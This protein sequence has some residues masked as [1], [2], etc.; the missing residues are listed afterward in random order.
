MADR[1][2]N[3]PN[4]PHYPADDEQPAWEN[5]DRTNQ[6]EPTPSEQ[7]SEIQYD[8]SDPTMSDASVDPQALPDEGLQIDEGAAVFRDDEVEDIVGSAEPDT[9]EMASSDFP[10]A[11]NDRRTF[12]GFEPAADSG[13]AKG[14]VPEADPYAEP[15]PAGEPRFAD[16]GAP[17][18]TAQ[19]T[20][21]AEPREAASV[22]EPQVAEEPIEQP[23]DYTAIPHH[24]SL[25]DQEIP[26]DVLERRQSPDDDYER[27]RELPADLQPETTET[28]EPADAPATG[29]EIDYS[30]WQE[31]ADPDSYPEVSQT[32]EEV[33]TEDAQGAPLDGAAAGVAGAAGAATAGAG[34]FGAVS[35][36][37]DDDLETTK[38]R[39]QSLLNPPEE[40]QADAEATSSW[41]PR[42][43][44]QQTD[45]VESSLFD[46]ATVVPE[47]PSR[48]GARVWSFFLTLIGLPA[49]WY[50]ITD[51]AARL[52]L[53]E[54]NP[55][56]TG[57]LNPAALA[58][59]GAGAVVAIIV[60][61]LTIRSSL[62]A[63][64][65]GFLTMVAG[66]FFLAV[67]TL[68]A[69]FMEP[70]YNWLTAFN[71]FG[72]NVAH[73]IQ[74]TGYT[75]AMLVSGLMLFVIGLTSIFARR[76]GRREQDIRTQIERLAP[77]TLKKGRRKKA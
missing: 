10:S 2:L 22:E 13:P 62:G 11:E 9:D 45:D 17:A 31:D 37:D 8:D 68:T 32:R 29:E 70:A 64:I 53:A 34:T 43:T 44:A 73:H 16:D 23:R 47:V 40:P 42:E 19:D 30:Q 52:T 25:N 59:L 35:A 4:D 49:A 24:V 61:M 39:R 38:V 7:D 48:V 41:H 1:N 12:S 60:I 76:D 58:E 27:M 6:S 75:G 26:R 74:W 21:F 69:D 3:E 57:N 72:G 55:L 54:G 28:T 56:A 67:P 36:E 71:D 20:P 77:G 63:L 15:A 66:G 51:A 46:D 5:S 18:E 14:A 65:F 33:H 50:L